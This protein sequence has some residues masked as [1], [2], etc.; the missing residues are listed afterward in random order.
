MLNSDTAIPAVSG[1]DVIRRPGRALVGW[2][3]EAE[4]IAAMLGRTPTP[5][6]D[7]AELRNRAAEARRSVE[8]RPVM[9]SSGAIVDETDPRLVAVQTRQDLASNFPGLK[10]RAAIVDL[11]KVLSFQKVIA[12][13]GLDDRL[14]GAEDTDQLLD[15]CLPTMQPM[16][17]LG[18][19]NDPD[20]KGFTLSSVNPNLRI[21]GAQV[22]SAD[23][24][25]E[26]GKP[27][28]R[29]QAVTFLIHMGTSYLQVVEYRG[30]CFV[31]DGYHRAAG[32]LR[33]GIQEV[34]CVFISAQ[35]FEEVGAVSG[36]LT[37][38]VLFGE[39]P[40]LV[41]DFWDDSVAAQIEPP[42]V[43]KIIRITGEEFAISR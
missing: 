42:A 37:Y 40:P 12:V 28:V 19:F 16:P 23:V 4:A 7:V 24:A 18:T 20:Q 30:R 11:S 39:R 14:A 25:P 22:G 29:M 43:R 13:D 8:S 17:P 6:D 15:L 26:P 36:M 35:S 34:P 2:M 33:R 31:R 41:A 3:A 5:A 9:T 32:L 21:A 27:A 38:E 1:E 10:W